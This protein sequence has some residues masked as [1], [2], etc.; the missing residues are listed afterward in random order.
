MAPYQI[1][2]VDDDLEDHM[3]LLDY[4]TEVGQQENVKFMLNGKELIDYLE[5]LNVI[6]LPNLIVLDL[7]M[8]LLNGTQ[9]LLHIKRDVRFKHIPVIIFSTSTNESEKRKCLSLGA[10]DYLVKP[11]TYADGKILI[12]KFLSYIV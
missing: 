9:T 3:I 11:S 7:N 6:S 12:H 10:I 1:L 2:V 4:F 5:L 8:P